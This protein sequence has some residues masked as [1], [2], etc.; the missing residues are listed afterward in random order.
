M[1]TTA[2]L[3]R[4]TTST[5]GVWRTVHARLAGRLAAGGVAAETAESP[6]SRRAQSAVGRVPGWCRRRSGC[7]RMAALGFGSRKDSARM[8]A[9]I[10]AESLSGCVGPEDRPQARGR[11]TGIF[12]VSGFDTHPEWDRT[13][14]VRCA[15]GEG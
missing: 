8:K 13:G 14:R 4:R 12:P 3:T 1:L 7:I 15:A 11:W 6:P 9:F 10:L 2:S 5:T